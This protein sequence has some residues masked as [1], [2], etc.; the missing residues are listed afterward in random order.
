MGAGIGRGADWE[1]TGVVGSV[2]GSDVPSSLFFSE[3]AT[4]ND[5]SKS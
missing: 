5:P 3:T 4:I 1:F 2:S